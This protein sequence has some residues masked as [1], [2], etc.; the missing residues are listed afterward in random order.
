M[1]VKTEKD[2]GHGK[3]GILGTRFALPPETNIEPDQM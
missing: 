2:T 3:D 1:R